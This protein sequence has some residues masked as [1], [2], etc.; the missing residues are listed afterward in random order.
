MAGSC[1]R[2]R[3]RLSPS[4]STSPRKR[5]LFLPRIP[6][7]STVSILLYPGLIVSF[8]MW[9]IIVPNSRK[10]LPNGRRTYMLYTIAVILVVLWLIGLVSSYTMGGLIHI[11]LAIAVIVILLQVINERK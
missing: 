3:P 11:L 1:T 6:H 2:C 9:R 4:L 7:S 5:A 10:S 8:F